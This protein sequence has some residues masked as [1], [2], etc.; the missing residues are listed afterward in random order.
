MSFIFE[1]SPTREGRTASRLSEAIRRQ[2]ARARVRV[3]Q[4]GVTVCRQLN[5]NA[6]ITS[7]IFIR[8]Y[9]K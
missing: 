6:K 8:G 7:P 2:E 3:T 1:L 5:L 9:K 4:T